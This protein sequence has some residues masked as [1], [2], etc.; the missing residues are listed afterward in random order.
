MLKTVLF[1]C[2]HNAGR[3]QMAAAFFNRLAGK[4][5]EVI[6]AGTQPADT[7]NPVVVQ[8]MKEV[9]IDISSARPQMLT[10]ELV[11]KAEKMITMGCGADAGGVCPAGFLETEDWALD[12]PHGQAIEAVRKI[13]DEVEKRVEKL[14][15][16][17]RLMNEQ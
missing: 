13:R 2:V 1:I 5:A 3:S 14:L 11:E 12:D 6:S 4:K 10:A 8:A 15:T 9:G 7:V 17:M 16:E